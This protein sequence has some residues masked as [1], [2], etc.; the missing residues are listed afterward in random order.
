ME[1]ITRESGVIEAANLDLVGRYLQALG[2]GAGGDELR[3]FV[4]DAVVFEE[5]PNRLFPNGRVRRLEVAMADADRGRYLM[6]GQSYLVRAAVAQ[7]DTVAVEAEW[8]GTL[9]VALGA[10]PAGYEMRARSAMF[11]EVRAG[12]I[13]AQR[14]YDCFDPW[15]P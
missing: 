2:A 9:A 11:I 7:G 8:R 6:K 5:L 14:N 12:K 1:R 13:V 3:Q 4:D 15:P 10:L